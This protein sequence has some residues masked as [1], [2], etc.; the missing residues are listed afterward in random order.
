MRFTSMV[1]VALLAVSASVS[2]QTVLENFEHGNEALWN[3]QTAGDNMSLTAGSAFAGNFGA[4]FTTGGSGFRTR[5]DLGTSPGNQY[6]AMVRTRGASGTVGRA[7][8][9]I[10]ATAAGGTWTAVFAPNTSQLLLQ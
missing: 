8:L 9:G 2:A 1:G 5:F 7:Y 3:Q 6:F 10:G 4:E